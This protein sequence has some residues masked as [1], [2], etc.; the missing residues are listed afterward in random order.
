MDF[1]QSLCDVGGLRVGHASDAQLKSGVT[2]LIA[3]APVVMAVDVR[4][5]GPG[6]RETDALAPHNLV[7][8]VHGLVL[9]GGSVFGLGA[10]DRVADLL[11]QQGIGL[12]L[13]PRAVPVIPAAIIFDLANGGDK[14]WAQSP[15]PALGEKALAALAICDAQGAVGAGYGARA[16]SRAGGL[17][18]ASCLTQN[19]AVVAALMVVNSFGE[20][21]GDAPPSGAVPMPKMA[22]GQAAAG[23]NTSIGVVATN[24]PLSRVQALRLAM[25]AQ[26]GLARAIRPIHT[27]F[28]GDMI[29]ALST[30]ASGTSD[31]IDAVQLTEIGTL[32]ADCVAQAVRRAVSL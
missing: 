4:G 13:G 26:D 10:A 6:T 28:D 32:A 11:S 7:E 27:P 31:A 17:G 22:L 3:D 19:G 9:A 30:A 20:V 12:P 29:F 21:Y 14:Q 15:Y 1:G 24:A 25:M 23:M 2:V 5:G 18:M 16:G 8:R